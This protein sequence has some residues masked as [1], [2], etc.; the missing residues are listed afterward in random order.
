MSDF[1]EYANEIARPA[2]Q[3]RNGQAVTH[4]ARDGT[5][6]AATA[7]VGEESTERNYGDDGE[8]QRRVCKVTLFKNE[9]ATVE[10]KDHVTIAGESWA[11]DEILAETP[12]ETHFQ[13]ARSE[14]VEVSRPEYRQQ[15]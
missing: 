13:V 4:V 10:M 7:I 6:T 3:Q 9:V 8:K 2:L 5:Q 11:I 15:S 14:G 12:T 1:D